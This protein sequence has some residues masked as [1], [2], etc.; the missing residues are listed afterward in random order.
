MPKRK[1]SSLGSRWTAAKAASR[2]RARKAARVRPT[3]P[4]RDARSYTTVV[5]P[6]GPVAQRTIV[7]LKYCDDKQSDGTTLDYLWNLN[8]LYD[9]DRSG[10]GHQ[11]YGFDTY[12]TLYNRYRVFAV[13]AIVRTCVGAST[14]A[15]QKV[16]LW[17]DN[18]ASTFGNINE[19]E[20]QPSAITKVATYGA[21]SFIRRKFYLPAIN[22]ATKTQYKSDDRFQA[23]VSTSPSETIIMHLAHCTLGTN[24]TPASGAVS[25]SITFVFYCE[26]FDPK[27]LGAS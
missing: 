26:F 7:R 9:P 17:P 11:P 21:P 1:Y 6:R 5:V 2:K 20:E 8:S 14:T 12:A 13:E 25:H 19:M 16:C 15:P 18:T 23:L 4:P 24:G 10:T 27:S 3:I 22:G